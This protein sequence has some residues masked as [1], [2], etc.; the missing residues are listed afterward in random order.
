MKLGFHE[1]Q[2][3]YSSGSQKARIWT[4]RWASDWLYCPNCG[5][6][7][8]TQLPPNIPVADFYCTSCGDQ[9]E[10]KSKNGSFGSKLANGAYE[11]KCERLGS[12]TN[13]N[14]ILLNY[15]LRARPSETFCSFPSTFSLLR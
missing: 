14:L 8:I 12:S 9:Y 11:T 4:E 15:D 3:A 10:L 5:N 7:R 6:E 1:I 13:P 2:A